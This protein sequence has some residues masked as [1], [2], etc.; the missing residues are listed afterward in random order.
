MVWL[1]ETKLCQKDTIMIHGYRQPYSVHSNKKH[2]R[3]HYKRSWK[4]F[5]TSNNELDWP[6]HKEKNKKVIW[7]MK[8]KL[9]GKNYDTTCHIEI[10]NIQIFNRW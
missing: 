6:L 3:R 2:L 7:L 10:R 5:D 9:G 8:H 1:P 4:R